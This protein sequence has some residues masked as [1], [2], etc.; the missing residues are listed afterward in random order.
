MSAPDIA[1]QVLTVGDRVATLTPR[2]RY[3][4]SLGTLVKF[5]PKGCK[6]QLDETRHA[7]EPIQLDTAQV[8]RIPKDELMSCLVG[9][10]SGHKYVIPVAKLEAWETFCVSPDH[11]DGNV[12]DWA[13]RVDGRLVFS[14]WRML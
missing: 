12:P 10:N 3:K 7:D 14:M 6:V 2:Y 4:L 5:T 8:V 1:G 13:T 9:D 11:D